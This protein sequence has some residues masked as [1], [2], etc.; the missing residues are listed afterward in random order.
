MYGRSWVLFPSGTQIFSLSKAP[1][2]LNIPSF[3]FSLYFFRS[4]KFTIFP[5]LLIK[6]M[7]YN[8]QCT[9]D[10]RRQGDICLPGLSQ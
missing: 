9:R 2:K 1:D 3:L 5:P 10:V 6:I 8:H 7:V 4:L